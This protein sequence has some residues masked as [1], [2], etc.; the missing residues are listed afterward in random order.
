M[1]R[2]CTIFNVLHGWSRDKRTNQNSA[3]N[4]NKALYSC[5]LSGS[6]ENRALERCRSTAEW[7]LG[8]SFC[9]FNV[10]DFRLFICDYFCFQYFIGNL[11]HRLFLTGVSTDWLL[12][13]FFQPLFPNFKCLNSDTEKIFHNSFS[14]ELCLT[15]R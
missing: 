12:I 2:T 4:P 9:P 3:P 5:R 6:N 1:G 7:S 14:S 8:A 10:S 15:K 11:F 13:D